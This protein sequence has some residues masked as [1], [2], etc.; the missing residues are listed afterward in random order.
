MNNY[1]RFLNWI[2]ER[3]ALNDWQN[4]LWNGGL[5]VSEMSREIGCNPR[6]LTGQNRKI[7]ERMEELVGDLTEKGI[8]TPNK[9]AQP[10]QSPNGAAKDRQ[11]AKLR[12]ENNALKESNSQ[13]RAKLQD[14]ESQLEQLG[15]LGDILEETGRI[16]Y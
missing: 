12:A 11:I 3:Y 5:N 8:L 13:L 2:E 1:Q 6:A 4:Y 7:D 10:E 16:P 14:L 15:L 9:S